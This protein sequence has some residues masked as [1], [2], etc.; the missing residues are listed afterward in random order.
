M[1]LVN[2][3]SLI[4]IVFDMHYLKNNTRNQHLLQH[5]VL[6]FLCWQCPFQGWNL[7]HNPDNTEQI[8]KWHSPECYPVVKGHGDQK[9][10][11]FFA[12]WYPSRVF[13][14]TQSQ[15][16]RLRGLETCQCT[17][18][19]TRIVRLWSLFQRQS[20]CHC[21]SMVAHKTKLTAVA[22][23]S[24]TQQPPQEF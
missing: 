8:T 18:V 5:K 3:E 23:K 17:V 10:M 9:Q 13:H 12:Y 4:Y 15:D 22:S 11:P 19:S 6:F 20:T 14:M 21:L 24:S 7:Q 16:Q 2:V 1:H